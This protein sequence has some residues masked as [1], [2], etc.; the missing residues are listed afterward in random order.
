MDK[1]TKTCR[2]SVVLVS[3][4]FVGFF[5]SPS[6]A[7]AAASLYV[8]PA[9]GS[10]TSG[11]T[12][13]VSIYVD[14][15]GQSVN[16]V[17]ANLTFPPDKLQVASP[18][19]GRSSIQVWVNQPSYDNLNGTLNFQGAI[20]AP[21]LNTDGGLISTVT[22]R[23]KSIG[24]AVLKFSDS[25]RVLLNDGRGTNVLG[26]M[27]DGV[28]YLTLPPPAGPIVTSRTNPDQ[29]KWYNT[30]TVSLEWTSPPDIEGYSY[31]LDQNPVTDVDDVPEGIKTRAVYNNLADGVYYFHI[32]TL[33]SGSWG[34]ITDYII[35]VDNTP[36]ASFKVNISPSRQTSNRRPIIDFATTDAASGIDHYELNITSLDKQLALASQGNNPFFIEAAPPYSRNLDE[37]RYKV[38]VKAYDKAGNYYQTEQNLTITKL[39]FEFIYLEGIGIGE[40][41]IPWIYALPLGAVILIGLFY[42]AKLLW[43]RHREIEEHLAHGGLKHPSILPGLEELKKMRERFKGYGGRHLAIALIFAIVFSLSMFAGIPAKA[44]QSQSQATDNVPLQPPVVTLF[45][46]AISNDE[47]LYIGGNAGIPQAKVL[48]YL[49]NLETGST[50]GETATTDKDGSWFFSFPKFFDAGKYIA[51]TQLQ[52]GDSVSPPSPRVDLSVAKTAIQIGGK[53]LSFENLYLVLFIIFIVAFLGLL[54]YTV[55]HAYHYN[56]KKRRLNAMLKEAEESVRRGFSILKRDI[57]AELNVIRKV[58]LSKE[59]SVEEKLREEKLMKDLDAVSRYIGKEVWEVEEESGRG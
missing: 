36:P 57:E 2:F 30:K 6:G 16:A 37:G 14:T 15:G 39:F 13:S 25:S 55:Y 20:P 22:F 53:R 7:N 24:T 17:E 19:A 5:I 12:F 28:Y 52:N 45:P 59:I 54:A 4:L 46:Q 51:W 9:S 21:G 27:T 3:A 42:F 47:I 8:S 58:K 40:Y 18:T 43:E 38:I 48:I 11:S 34:G 50:I 33:R 41:V 26:Q 1:Q 23:V 49:Q 32:K 10:F 29:E 44:A 56:V 31:I 35:N